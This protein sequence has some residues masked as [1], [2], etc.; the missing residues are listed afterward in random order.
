MDGINNQSVLT[1]IFLDCSGW[2]S[3]SSVLVTFCACVC[4]C[5]SLS[6]GP[7]ELVQE[8]YDRIFQKGCLICAFD[9]VLLAIFCENHG[10]SIDVKNNNSQS[11]K[12]INSNKDTIQPANKKVVH[13]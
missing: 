3:D 12:D 4:L 2:I 13:Y 11:N 10:R 1:S 6:I 9:L 8:K 7:S 5:I